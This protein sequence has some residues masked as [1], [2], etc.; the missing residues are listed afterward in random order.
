MSF[1]H[2]RLGEVVPVPTHLPQIQQTNTI[3]TFQPPSV[4]HVA[5]TKQPYGSGDTNDYNLV[6]P[7]LDA[8]HEWRLKE[9]ETQMVE[10]VKVRR[11]PFDL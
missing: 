6:F 11:L 2:F 7:N 9:E 5:P 10:F 3:Q 1:Q 4:N 8:F